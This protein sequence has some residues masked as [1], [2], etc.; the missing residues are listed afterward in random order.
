MSPFASTVKKGAQVLNGAS[1]LIKHMTNVFGLKSSSHKL[2]GWEDWDVVDDKGL[3]VVDPHPTDQIIID[4]E[5]Y[6]DEEDDEIFVIESDNDDQPKSREIKE[7]NWRDKTPECI[8]QIEDQ[9]ECGS[10]WAF[11]SSGLLADRFCIH[12]N[13]VINTRFSPQEMINCNY[14]NFGCSGGYL[15]TTIDYLQ[16]E[17]LVSNKCVPYAQQMNSCT[18]RCNDPAIPIERYYC[19]IGSFKVMTTHREIINDL[20]KNGPMMMGLMIFED[21]MSYSEGIY[22]QTTGQMIGGHAMKLIGFG[23]DPELGLYWIL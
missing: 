1:E 17:G 19:E 2:K 6:F 21:F 14:E 3:P 15:M 18:Y 13:G 22:V 8:G 9:G 5:I 7:F 12:S 23:E 4:G 11:S 20:I 10:C 16:I